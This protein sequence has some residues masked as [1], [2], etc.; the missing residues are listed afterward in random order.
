MRR[1]IF[2]PRSRWSG[3]KLPKL[4][5]K[6][7]SRSRLNLSYNPRPTKRY[8]LSNPPSQFYLYRFLPLQLFAFSRLCRRIDRVCAPDLLATAVKQEPMLLELQTPNSDPKESTPVL[9][10]F[11]DDVEN[12]DL[13][14]STSARCP[15]S[16]GK[17]CVLSVSRCYCDLRCNLRAFLKRLAIK[18]TFFVTRISSVPAL[19]LG[20]SHTPVPRS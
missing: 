17:Y 5:V 16:L 11:L 18:T 12:S 19:R 8:P 15:R 20:Y 1:R 2:L 14:E 6:H 9:A 10:R 4:E 7:V 13:K 3:S